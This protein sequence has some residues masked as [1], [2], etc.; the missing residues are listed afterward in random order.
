MIEYNGF[1]SFH[2]YCILIRKVAI[3]DTCLFQV[4]YSIHNVVGFNI[5]SL[6]HRIYMPKKNTSS[7]TTFR[8][9]LVLC[10]FLVVNTYPRCKKNKLLKHVKIIAFLRS[11]S[12]WMQIIYII[13]II[14]FNPNIYLTYCTALMKSHN[15]YLFY[16]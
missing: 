10:T 6:N 4:R 8:H 1:I 14:F 2:K 12:Y 5:S 9:F 3:K 13:D 16:D 15:Y 11:G 7:P